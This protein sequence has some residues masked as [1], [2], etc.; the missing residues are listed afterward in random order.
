V[1]YTIL[2]LQRA[3]AL[4]VQ[5]V[6]VLQTDAQV[7]LTLLKADLGYAGLAFPKTDTAIVSYN[8]DGLNGEDA[9][10]IRA[11]G[12][13]FESARTK[14]SWLLGAAD[15]QIVLVRGWAD[16]SF[17]FDIGDTV[18]CLDANRIIM[19]PPGEMVITNASPDSF[20]DPILGPIFA[21]SL[22]LS[23]YLKGVP[24]LI[25]IRKFGSTYS[26]GLRLE[27]ANNK[28]VRG[29]DTLLDNVEDLQLA[30]G[31]DTDDD[32]LIDSWTNDAP[33][34][35]STRSKW[36]IRYTL[37]LTSERL[38]D[39]TYP[40]DTVSVEDHAYVLNSDQ[41]KMRRVFLAPPNLQP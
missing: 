12:L 36:A 1:T 21:Q 29:P 7:S 19:R 20:I 27:V 38:G 5:K 30:Y 24:G 14:W 10:M 3:K 41:K 8:H 18:V 17:N 40:D 35:A 2:N 6:S 22:T 37:V 39:Y 33:T 11:A 16:T 28:L 31:I 15:G 25:I 26:P 13:G 32:D 23:A 4:T 9:I 34:F